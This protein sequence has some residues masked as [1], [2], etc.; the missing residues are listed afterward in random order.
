[1][2][3]RPDL[4]NSKSLA[5]PSV[6]LRPLSQ[7]VIFQI[8]DMHSTPVTVIDPSLGKPVSTEEKEG[9]SYQNCGQ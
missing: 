5:P 2:H 7:W 4:K 9:N 3:T 1:M 6:Q 8:L